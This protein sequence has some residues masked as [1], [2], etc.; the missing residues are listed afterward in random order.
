M[1]GLDVA[2]ALGAAVLS[3]LWLRKARGDWKARLGGVAPLAPVAPGRRRVLLHAVSVGEVNAL[4]TLVPMLAAEHEVVVSTT[5]DTGMARALELYGTGHAVVRY[6]LDFSRS[7]GRFLDAV[8]PDVVGLVELEVWPNFVGACAKRG[9]AVAVVNGRLSARSFRGYRRLR[10]VL[11]PTFARLAAVSA[12]DEVYRQRFLAMGVRPEV[13]AVGG[14]MK[15][16]TASGGDPA[17]LERQAEALAEG[18]GVD[19]SRLVVVAGSTAAGEERLLH[20]SVGRGVQLICAPRRPERFDEAAAAMPGCAR[21]SGGRSPSSLNLSTSRDRFLLD[22]IGELRAA[23][24]LADVVVVG[25]S[26]GLGAHGSGGSDPI[27]PVALGRATLIGPRF[28]NFESVVGA[29]REGGALR[30]A[31]AGELRVVLG[32]LLGSE[33]RRR[34]MGEAGRRVIAAQRGATSRIGA[35]LASLASRGGSVGAVGAGAA[36]PTGG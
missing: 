16:D 33:R 32:E 21:R 27:E 17:E 36:G 20:E 19:R 30:V 14:S 9:V 28:A 22:T 29:L 1:N 13:C 3:P 23:Y 8:R 31:N 26:F 10:A 11:S 12:Q 6:P 35:L 2:Y 15:W 7:V 5:T 34:E 18:L 24:A 25:R 4:R